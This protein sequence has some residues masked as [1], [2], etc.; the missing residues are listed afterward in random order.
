MDQDKSVTQE[1]YE[2]LDLSDVNDTERSQLATTLYPG[3]K[4]QQQA[5]LSWVQNLPQHHQHAFSAAGSVQQRLPQQQSQHPEQEEG[6]CQR[7]VDHD[8]TVINS[9]NE[10]P[11]VNG[12]TYDKTPSETETESSVT[13][14]YTEFAHQQHQTHQ[15]SSNIEMSPHSHHQ[16][17]TQHHTQGSAAGQQQHQGPGMQQTPGAQQQHSSVA[18]SMYSAGGSQIGQPTYMTQGSHVYQMVQ[19]PMPNNVYVSNVIANLNF[20]NMSA[21]MPQPF[22]PSAGPPT[23]FIPNDMQGQSMVAAP[24]SHD[25]VPTLVHPPPPLTGTRMSGGSRRG[26]GNKS[27]G[28][29]RRG[30]G[31]GDYVSRQSQEQQ[32]QEQQHR[33]QQ[34]QQQQQQQG[35]GGPPEMMQHMI[36]PQQV[37]GTPGY[38]P[39]I[40]YNYPNYYPAHNIMPHP[41]TQHATGPPLYLQNPMQMYS[42]AHQ[43]AY[44]HPPGMFMYPPAMMSP[45]YAVIDDKGDDQS[46]MSDGGSVVGQMWSPQMQMDYTMEPNLGGPQGQEE[47]IV[48]PDMMEDPTGL[49]IPPMIS[50]QQPP[51][52][53]PNPQTSHHVLNPDVANFMTMKQQMEQQQAQ[54][55]DQIVQQQQQQQMMPT[56]YLQNAQT[57]QAIA[58]TMTHTTPITTN[59]LPISVVNAVPIEEENPD[60]ATPQN[61]ITA[62]LPQA[63]DIVEEC[64]I[65]REIPSVQHLVEQHKDLVEEIVVATEKVHIP[66]ATVAPVPIS[67]VDSMSQQQS[68]T[69]SS[70]SKEVQSSVTATSSNNPSTII[71]NTSKCTKSSATSSV[72]YTE[73]ANSNNNNNNVVKSKEFDDGSRVAKIATNDKL[74]L[75]NERGQK[76][77]AWSKKSTTSVS[78]T[79]LP[80]S[81]PITTSQTANITDTTTKQQQQQQIKVTPPPFASQ[82]TSPKVLFTTQ[83]TKGIENEGKLLNQNENV[84]SVAAC[85]DKKTEGAMLLN[86]T[87]QA[88]PMQHH[89][90]TFESKQV[91]V[92]PQIQEKT[93]GVVSNENVVDVVG[94]VTANGTTSDGGSVAA[95]RVVKAEVSPS[96]TLPPL[97]PSTAP[98]PSKSWASLFSSDSS[99]SALG[100][101]GHTTN[102]KP[103]AKVPP[104]EPTPSLPIGGL[105]YSAAS[106]LGLPAAAQVAATETT[107]VAALT[108]KSTKSTVDDRC[109]KLGEF[110]SKYQIDNSSVILCPRGLTNRSNFCYINAILQALVACPPFYHMM[111]KLPLEPPAFRQKSSTPIIDA[112]VELVSEFSTMPP[113][114][115]LGKREKGSKSKDE[116][117][118]MCD[119]AFEPTVIH[120]MLSSSR[121]EFHVEGRQEDAEEFLGFI[122]NGLN[123]EML[124]LIKLVDKQPNIS[125]GEQA[126]GEVQSEEGG[127]D[128]WQ[129]IY[130]NR[131]KGTVTRTTDFGRT[132][133][134]DIFGGQLRSRVQR[135]GD[136]ST[137]VIQPFFTLQ[138]DIEKAESVKEALE[139]LV[140][141]DQLEGVTCS[142]T[143]QEVA[144]WQ[145]VTLEKLPVVLI[146]HLKWFDYKMDSCTKILKTVEFP[147]ELRVDT[148]ILSS[149]KCVPKQRQYKLFAVVYH[150]GKEASKGHYITD[151]FNIGYASWIRYDDSTVRSVSEHT[152]LHPH[153][154]KVPYLLYYRRCDTI[155]PQGQSTSTVK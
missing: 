128:D 130:G 72:I 120:K 3:E 9:W 119:M 18:A 108:A 98:P 65:P 56:E 145:Q 148:K 22:M 122:L 36:D 38:A 21:Q 95:E 12:N 139:I 105:S 11:Y 79:A 10:T 117:D 127:G 102:K 75:K 64:E 67:I 121:S 110:L 46:V 134:S 54:Q 124:E 100:S 149:K 33:Q 99:S 16:N 49:M 125:N 118:L 91:E 32:R 55:A 5:H 154:P 138:L 52:P 80:P 60:T 66:A 151:V 43:M 48:Q 76:P 4:Q 51:P 13:T 143:N 41:A 39:Q 141:K 50:P 137:D 93:V 42:G 69:V 109:Y 17:Q 73:N 144:A 123:D 45:E 82:K 136:H 81:T 8:P 27:G 140:V 6:V 78:V 104:F 74:M 24:T 133:I 113:G 116:I 135:E 19:P 132:P 34:Q 112:M 29:H 107:K 111:K 70:S 40:Y 84:A 25:A 30:G 59:S 85:M 129:V 2:F 150:D 106:A 71:I 114:A 37:M 31:G 61:I 90:T 58:N 77:P 126:N 26:R 83:V 142:K 44:G 153:L 131:N 96:A 86:K 89:L 101:G 23:A 1:C 94:K 88:I 147:I 15:Q 28:S 103:V 152:V 20:H 57:N 155:G 47:Y 53:P 7:E 146:L 14:D 97:A 92:L 35:S 68:D 63:A 115:R 87:V 62:S